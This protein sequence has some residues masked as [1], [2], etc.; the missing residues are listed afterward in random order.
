MLLHELEKSFCN[1]EPMWTYKVVQQNNTATNYKLLSEAHI[2]NDVMLGV[3]SI[4]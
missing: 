4:Y 3:S 1:A 2:I